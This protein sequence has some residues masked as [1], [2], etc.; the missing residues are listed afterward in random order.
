[1]P[2]WENFL[3]VDEIW[4]VILFLSEFTG[5]EPRTFGEAAH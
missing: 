4:D 2:V 1:M 3:T 5:Y